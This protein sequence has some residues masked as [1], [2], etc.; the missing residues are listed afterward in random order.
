MPSSAR[1]LKSAKD[2]STPKARSATRSWFGSSSHVPTLRRSLI[3][4]VLAIILGAGLS[5]GLPVAFLVA[6]ALVLLTSIAFLWLSVRTL[7]AHSSELRPVDPAPSLADEG[8]EKRQ[9]LGAI[10]D[11]TDEHTLGKID[12]EDYAL[13][14]ARSREQAKNVLRDL[15][16]DAAPFREAAE[17]LASRYLQK[18]GVAKV[19]GTRSATTDRAG[20]RKDGTPAMRRSCS[21]CQTV[22]D[23]DASFCKR[24][25]MR[26]PVET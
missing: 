8:D 18:H 2:V 21:S 4:L 1:S 17:D 3:L 6:A 24:C 7:A 26:F 13:A 19:P 12:D 11:L 5:G 15:A 10:R 16:R 9:A 22:N 23:G 25:G 14:M 20:R